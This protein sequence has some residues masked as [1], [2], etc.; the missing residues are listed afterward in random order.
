MEVYGISSP[1]ATVLAGGGMVQCGNGFKLNLENLAAHNK[2]EHDASMVSL[3]SPTRFESLILAKAHLDTKEGNQ[4]VVNQRLVEAMVAD[5]DGVAATE[6]DFIKMKVRRERETQVKYI[7][8]SQAN[9]SRGEI[10]L[11][12]SVMVDHATGR[13]PVE[14]IRTWFGEERLPADFKRPPPQTVGLL[15]I[16][17]KSQ[18]IS[19][20]VDDLVMEKKE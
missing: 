18:A 2:L 6:D 8:G 11:A 5:T 10:A 7:S 19:K 9:I 16:L 3:A 17:R 14:W 15:E 12:L 1:F 4:G 20:K 13:M